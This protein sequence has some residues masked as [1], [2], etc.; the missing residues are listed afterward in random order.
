[1]YT[2][3]ICFVSISKLCIFVSTLIVTLIL[4]TLQ[5]YKAWATWAYW[6]AEIIRLGTFFHHTKTASG[7]FGEFLHLLALS[8]APLMHH[9]QIMKWKLQS[10]NVVS[11]TSYIILLPVIITRQYCSQRRI[12]L[13]TSRPRGYNLLYAPPFTQLLTWILHHQWLKWPKLA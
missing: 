9:L 5:G 3:K 6:V 8:T 2:I 13:K 11:I 10:W 12:S 4:Q 7:K 1:M